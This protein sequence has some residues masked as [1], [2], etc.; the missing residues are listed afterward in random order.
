[1]GVTIIKK[2]SVNNTTYA[3]SRNLSYIVVHY[4]AGVYSYCGV[5]RN[6]ASMFSD[7]NFEA[8]ADFI[9]DSEEIVQF[10]GDIKNRYCWSVGGGYLGTK[11]G[12]FYGKCTNAN[13]ISIEMCCDN[14]SGKITWANDPRFTLNDKVV[15]NTVNLVKHLMETYNIPASRVIRHYDVTGKLCP[16]VIGWNEDS[17]DVSKWQAFK[18]KISGTDTKQASE[19]KE[20][21]S[22]STT[23]TNFTP[24]YIVRTANNLVILAEP[25]IYSKRIGICEKGSYTI[26]REKNVKGRQFGN[27]KAGGWIVINSCKKLSLRDAGRT[28]STAKPTTKKKTTDELAKDIIAGRYGCGEARFAKLAAEGYTD[29]EID[30]AQNKV[31]E[32]LSGGSVKV[33]KKTTKELAYSIIRGDYGCGD[34]RFKKLAAEGYTDVEINAAQT[35]VNELLK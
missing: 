5:A 17:G 12:S 6:C 14:S 10:N 23:A 18:K 11:G 4:T 7:P 2:T 35:L 28:T 20:T 30:A 8:S 19:T 1:M 16:G 33:K 29:K 25:D 3:P 15:N 32:L 22:T 24:P 9:V 13:S 26:V 21:N 27:L 31:N 34:A